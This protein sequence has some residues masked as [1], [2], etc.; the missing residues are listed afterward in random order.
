MINNQLE[1]LLKDIGPLFQ[2]PDLAP[3]SSNKC[4]IK[5][6][7]DLKLQFEQDKYDNLII[8]VRIGTLQIG[9]YRESIF[10]EALKA[11]FLHGTHLGTFGYVEKTGSLILFIF[12]DS[13]YVTSDRVKTILPA[14]L[15]KAQKWKEAIESGEVPSVSQGAS[16][17]KASLFGMMR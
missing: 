11:N 15:E 4:T 17:Q 14:F 5:L 3:D 2:L 13:R 12:I 1:S 9:R 6:A 16:V 10:K 8:G 7:N